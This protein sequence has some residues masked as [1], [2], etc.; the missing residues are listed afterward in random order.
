MHMYGSIIQSPAKEK[1]SEKKV[2]E[3]II[4]S[5]MLTPTQ[6][7][8]IDGLI[9]S[10]LPESKRKRSSGAEIKLTSVKP[11]ATK[12]DIGFRHFPGSPYR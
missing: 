1:M 11:S 7:E 3:G 8:D 2:M 6:R 9:K 4:Q 10:G 12:K 5:A